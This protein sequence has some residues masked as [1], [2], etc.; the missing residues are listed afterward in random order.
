MISRLLAFL[1]LV[2]LTACGT[3]VAKDTARQGSSSSPDTMVLEE[4]SSSADAVWGEISHEPND[5][6]SARLYAQL[7]SLTLT[8]GWLLSAEQRGAAVFTLPS[9]RTLGE[10]ERTKDFFAVT[11]RPAGTCTAEVIALRNTGPD[12]G[13]QAEAE[14]HIE[15]VQAGGKTVGYTWI[16]YDVNYG[17]RHWCVM[18]AG[19][20]G[21]EISARKD[22]APTV[23]FV[24]GTFIPHWLR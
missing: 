21:I 20:P 6:V 10:T 18:K 12:W 4:S 22:D 2:L 23:A 16:G 3:N 17:D 8:G 15:A 24:Q 14:G 7:Q 13:M 19:N 9:A 1:G 11:D 5:P